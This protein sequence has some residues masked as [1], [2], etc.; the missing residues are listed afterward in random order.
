MCA[1]LHNKCLCVGK[2]KQHVVSKTDT[3]LYSSLF[4]TPSL[5][6]VLQV[7]KIL[8]TGALGGSR[9]IF[10]RYDDFCSLKEEVRSK[11]VKVL[12]LVMQQKDNSFLY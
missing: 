11:R 7:Y 3:F 10:R 6:S 2:L 8:V 9:V 4:L 12:K 5:V 1:N